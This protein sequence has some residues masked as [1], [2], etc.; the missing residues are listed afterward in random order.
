MTCMIHFFRMLVHALFCLLHPWFT[1]VSGIPLDWNTLT[2]SPCTFPLQLLLETNSAMNS[3]NSFWG[4][5]T[6]CWFDTCNKGTF[7]CNMCLEGDMNDGSCLQIWIIF[8]LF[9]IQNL[10]IFISPY[11]I[12]SKMLWFLYL[13]YHLFVPVCVLCLCSHFKMCKL[14]TIAPLVDNPYPQKEVASVLLH[15]F[16]W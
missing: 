1:E 16:G 8:D 10:L 11:H 13:V 4:S 7:I 15:S 3:N 14:V 5:L 2:S 12:W 9:L 6:P